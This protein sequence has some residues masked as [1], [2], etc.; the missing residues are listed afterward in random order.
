M[1]QFAVY[2]ITNWTNEVLYAGVTSDLE[3][4]LWEHTNK[5][6]KGFTQKYNLNKLVY[7]EF[8]DTAENAI[9]R[10]KQI[11]RWSR[12]K[13]DALV[14][15]INPDWKDLAHDLVGSNPSTAG[16]ALRSG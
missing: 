4:R 13:K 12:A 16:F 6:A 14:D 2:F 3:K 15:K 9:L 7:Y 5:T 10:E 11:K 1:K 8:H